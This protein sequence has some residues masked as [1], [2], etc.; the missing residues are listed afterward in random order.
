MGET[1]VTHYHFDD[2]V[3]LQLVGQGTI[4]LVTLI[5]EDSKETFPWGTRKCEHRLGPLMLGA[6]DKALDLAEQTA[7]IRAVVVTGQGKFFSNGMDLKW[8][9]EQKGSSSSHSIDTIQKQ[10]EL[11]L[12]RLLC[13]SMPTIAAIN[14]HF[15]AAGAMLGL[16]FDFRIMDQDRGLCFVPGID[17]GLIYSPGMTELFLAKLPKHLHNDFIIYGERY[18]SEQLNKE[19]IVREIC[20][21]DKLV[22]RA[23]DFAIKLTAKG[24]FAG[25]KYRETMHSI[26]LNTYKRAYDAL[27]DDLNFQ[28]MGFEEGVWDQHGKSK[29]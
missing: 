29:L 26:K 24:R 11:L 8:I 21:G 2:V 22:S 5:G 13:F 17:L 25:P 15:C 27:R 9:D 3:S 1:T 7:S 16:A 23:I 20:N 14:G 18:N 10:A 12:S 28:G 19:G 4:A 6:L